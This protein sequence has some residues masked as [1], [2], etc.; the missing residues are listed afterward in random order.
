MSS[1]FEKN[2]MWLHPVDISVEWFVLGVLNLGTGEHS[3]PFP[4]DYLAMCGDI[5]GRHN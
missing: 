5:F 2:L 1:S 4:R 3:T